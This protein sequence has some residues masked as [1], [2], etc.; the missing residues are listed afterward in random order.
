M[1]SQ[2]PWWVDC[3]GRVDQRGRRGGPGCQCV[4]VSVGQ[5][6]EEPLLPCNRFT[7]GRRGDKK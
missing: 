5:W 3:R 1:V 4:R 2:S 7:R 6:I